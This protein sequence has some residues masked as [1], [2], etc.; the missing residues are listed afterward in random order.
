MKK[1]VSLLLLITIFTV[2]CISTGLISANAS[3]TFTDPT[4][5][6][7]SKSFTLGEQIKVNVNVNKNPGI[8]GAILKITYDSK[9]TLVEAES[10]EKFAKLNFTKPGK[11]ESPCTFLWDS[12]SGQVEDDGTI[13]TLTFDVSDDVAANEKLEIGISSSQGDIY[14]E[15]LDDVNF[16]QVGG[17]VS[18]KS[19]YSLG[20]VNRDGVINVQDATAIQMYV[21]E[22]KA[23]D[24]EALQLADI[25]KD[26]I[27]NVSDATRLRKYLAG[28]VASLEPDSKNDTFNVVFKDYDGTVIKSETINSGESAISPEE[29]QREGYIF[30]SW[31]KDFDKVTSDLVVTAQY[32]KITKPTVYIQDIQASAGDNVEIPVKIYNNPGINGMQLNISYDSNLTL[33]NAENGTALNSLYFTSPGSYTNP[34]KFLWDGIST[35]DAGNGVVLYLS[36]NIPENAKS[37]EEY[38][39]NVEYPEGSIFDSDLNDVNFDIVSGSIKIK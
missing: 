1:Y 39:I 12:E 15:N 6:V 38:L 11:F 26:G 14:N 33:I 24:S 4:I 5:F 13:L 36:F 3:T 2:S 28:T 22:T 18:L 35:N 17:F 10:G 27:I 9:L 30:L 20:D 21:A 31:D 19:P 32:S 7:E 34:S 16:K 25:I 37:G 29:P 23:L 8:A